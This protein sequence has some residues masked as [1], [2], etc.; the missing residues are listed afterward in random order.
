MLFPRTVAILSIF[1]L[2]LSL[3]FK[4]PPALRLQTEYIFMSKRTSVNIFLKIAVCNPL[5]FSALHSTSLNSK[6][7]QIA[8][9]KSMLTE[10]RLSPS[11][12]VQFAI[13]SM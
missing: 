13:N 1:S 3:K 12:G 11:L 5:L 4:S 2:I 6:G 8:I 10:V 7:L 9:S